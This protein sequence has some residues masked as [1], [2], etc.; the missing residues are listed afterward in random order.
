MNSN[1]ATTERMGR[2]AF[3]RDGCLWLGAAGLTT[4]DSAPLAATDA[5]PK[6]LVSI[7]LITDLHYADK[8]PAGTRFYRET[9]S[10]LAEATERFTQDKPD[11]LVELGDLVDAADTVAA[12]L[13]YLKTINRALRQAPGERH[14]VLGNHCVYTLTKQEFLAAVE[15]E[16]S[17]YSFDS[18]GYHFV[19]LDSCFRADGQPYERQNFAWNDANIPA[20]E[21]EWL[22]ADLASGTSPTIVFAHQRLDVA[23]NYGVKNAADVRQVIEDSA[24]VVAVFQGHSHEND[25]REIQGVHYCTLAAMVEGTGPENNSYAMLCILSDGSLRLSG[26]RRQN[27]YVW[28]V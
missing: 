11:L 14:Y 21:L 26:F 17:A 8:T 22:K 13:G 6:T 25:Y 27:N 23:N 16:K 12:E 5:Q 9:L 4:V 7:G 20:A 28:V 2:R 18:S 24:R 19:V 3:V 15:K 1:P 10:K